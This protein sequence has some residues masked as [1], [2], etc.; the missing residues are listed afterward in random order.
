M[1]TRED[2]EV[3]LIRI[4]LRIINTVNEKRFQGIFLITFMS[5]Y[6]TQRDFL[7]FI[8]LILSLGKRN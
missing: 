2:L 7:F 5:Q 3:I 1:L 6:C 8:I 4:Y